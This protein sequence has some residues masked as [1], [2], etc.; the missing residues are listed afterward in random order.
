[1]L[2]RFSQDSA[3][4]KN[5]IGRSGRQDGVGVHEATQRR[6]RRKLVCLRFSTTSY[7]ILDCDV[8]L[9]E[10]LVCMVWIL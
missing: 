9:I 2:S 6:K 8:F 1:M 5:D 4:S 3:T 7:L 10:A